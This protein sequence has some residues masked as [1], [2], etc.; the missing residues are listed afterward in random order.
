MEIEVVVVVVGVVVIIIQN[1]FISLYLFLYF[2]FLP[3]SWYFFNELFGVAVMSLSC[4]LV[5]F[6]M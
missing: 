6:T 1:F 3:I 5:Y 4:I 2:M